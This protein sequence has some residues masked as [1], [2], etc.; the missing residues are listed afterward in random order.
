MGESSTTEHH[1][2]RDD[3][4]DRDDFHREVDDVW[5]DDDYA[6]TGPVE[7][8]GRGLDFGLLMLRLGSLPLM[9]HGVHAAVDMTAFTDRVADT[10]LGAQ[11]PDFFAWLAMLA[12]VGL[13]VLIVLGL[14]TRPVAFV[15]SGEMA[16]AYWMFH[17]PRNFYPTL[18]GGDASILYCFVFL[19]LAAAG[20]GPWSLDALRR[21]GVADPGAGAAFGSR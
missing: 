4:D 17:A 8:H 7:A 2:D 21:R 18:N 12:L 13:P 20:P 1:D 14:F 6:L 3:R 5:D 19:Y 11:A 10:L 15:L 16:V 9:L